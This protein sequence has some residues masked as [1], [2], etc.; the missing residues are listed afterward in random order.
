[1]KETI[2]FLE[3]TV[4]SPERFERQQVSKKPFALHIRF[5]KLIQW[6][7]KVVLYIFP[8]N[9]VFYHEPFQPHDRHITHI[10]PCIIS[11]ILYVTYV[12]Y[13]KM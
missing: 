1:M 10:I 5:L 4:E 7:S 2:M 8:N 13:M 9:Q 3:H 11:Y 12:T 6:Q